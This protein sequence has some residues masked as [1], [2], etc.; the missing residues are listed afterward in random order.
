MEYANGPALDCFPFNILSVRRSRF[1]GWGGFWIW[2]KNVLIDAKP[3]QQFLLEQLD[4][5]IHNRL[6][7]FFEHHGSY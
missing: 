3:F 5:S 1:V 6:S 4:E 2:P 7:Y